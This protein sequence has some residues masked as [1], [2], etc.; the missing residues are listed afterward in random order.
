LGARCDPVF[1]L[2]VVPIMPYGFNAAFLYVEQWVRKGTAPPR[3]PRMELK[4]AGTPQANVVTDQA[5]NGVGGVRSPYVDVPIAT[6]IPTSTG[7]GNCREMGH[8]V[9]FDAARVRT[10]HGNEKDYAS[11][12]SQSVDKLVKERWLTEADGKKIKQS[13]S[14]RGGA[15]H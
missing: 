6:Y 3:A 13:L 2:D 9:D 1:P 11:K 15:N 10:L 4:D 7:P 12:M 14:A 8:K 5:G